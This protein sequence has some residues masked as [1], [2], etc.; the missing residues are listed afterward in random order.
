[1]RSS[2]DLEFIGK[3]RHFIGT[4]EK[5]RSFTASLVRFQGVRRRSAGIAIFVPVFAIFLAVLSPVRSGADIIE[6]S[7][8]RRFSLSVDLAASPIA[9]LSGSA[10]FPTLPHL[11][12]NGKLGLEA[13]FSERFAARIEAS[14]FRINPSSF[15][16]EGDLYRGWE[17]FSAGLLAGPIMKR[18][19]LR[20]GLYG[21]AGLTAARYSGTALV[22][23]YP[24]LHARLSIRIHDQSG[25][26]AFFAIPADI[27]LR[28]GTAGY[29]VAAE[30]GFSFEFGTKRNPR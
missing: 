1:M 3:R 10:G 12:F 21:G 4:L 26:G 29:S 16:T 5:I 25:F 9:L 13:L 23:A 19:D 20:A 22:F 2:R 17:G 27:L 18:G 15:S 24:S 14:A 7:S 8:P 28:G 6:A 30:A 11:G